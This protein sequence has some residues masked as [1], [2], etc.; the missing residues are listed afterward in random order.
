MSA[1]SII[2][3]GMHPFG[4]FPGKQA[5]DMGAEAIRL[6]LKDAGVGWEQVQRAYA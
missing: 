6:A 1:V 4:R 2:G 3:V 5:M